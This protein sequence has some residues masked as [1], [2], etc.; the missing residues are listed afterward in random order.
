MIFHIDDIQAEHDAGNMDNAQ[1]HREH[2]L[3]MIEK[4]NKA[5]FDLDVDLSY[6]PNDEAWFGRGQ[7]DFMTKIDDI[8]NGE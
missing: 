1:A 4:I 5:I 7:V 2:F 6:L 3:K 8:V